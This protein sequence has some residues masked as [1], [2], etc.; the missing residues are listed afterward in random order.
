MFQPEEFGELFDL[1][2]K[3][4]EECLYEVLLLVEELVVIVLDA[5]QPQLQDFIY[6]LALVEVGNRLAN[7]CT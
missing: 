1:D 6:E 4:V 2:V 3:L 7:E 5:M